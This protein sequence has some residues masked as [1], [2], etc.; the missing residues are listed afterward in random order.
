VGGAKR[1]RPAFFHMRKIKGF[2]MHLAE[3]CVI[4][5]LLAAMNV[6]V[7]LHYQWVIFAA[8]LWGFYLFMHGKLARPTGIEP[9]FPP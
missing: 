9:V 1:L 7:S 3:Y 5:A 6:F 2:Y 4:I 8:I